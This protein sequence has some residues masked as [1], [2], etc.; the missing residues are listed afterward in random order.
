MDARNPHPDV[1]RRI[2]EHLRAIDNALAAK[3]VPLAE[4]HSVTGDVE[5]QIREMLAEQAGASPTPADV[6]AILQKLDPPESY[7]EDAEA[8]QAEAARSAAPPTE[9]PQTSGKA[10]ASLV[11]GPC[12]FLCGMAAMALS[13]FKGIASAGALCGLLGAI[14][15]IVGLIFGIMALSDIRRSGG[16]LKGRGLATA[17]T[18]ISGVVLIFL[19][20]FCA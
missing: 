15:A 7:A 12:G 10:I 2:S 19:A 6:E 8:S 16:R 11:L 1:E 17:G 14:A 5:T 20:A 18:V 3:G 4:R 9:L 13:N